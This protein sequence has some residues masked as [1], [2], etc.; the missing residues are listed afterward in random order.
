MALS[1]LSDRCDRCSAQAFVQVTSRTTGYD[2]LFCGH[3][4]VENA[5]P[6]VMGGWVV[7]D[8]RDQINTAPFASSA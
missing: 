7:D 8:Q 1:R 3:H 2:L 5:E 4:Y 6:L